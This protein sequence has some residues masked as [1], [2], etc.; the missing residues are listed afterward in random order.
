MSE[1]IYFNAPES[2]MRVLSPKRMELLRD[3]H[4]AGAMNVLDL[5]KHLGRDYG[6]IHSDVLLLKQCNLVEQKGDNVSIP[7]DVIRVTFDLRKAA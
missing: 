1:T 7:Y 3:L 6:D 4:H 5:S 2:V